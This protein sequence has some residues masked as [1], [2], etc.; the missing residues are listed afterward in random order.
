MEIFAKIATSL[1]GKI[2]LHN[3]ISKWI[4]C[5]ESRLI[6]HEL[7]AKAD[8]ILTSSTTAIK[9]NATLNVRLKNDI[10]VTQPKRILIDTDLKTPIDYNIFN[11]ENAGQTIVFCSKFA[12]ENKKQQLIKNNIEIYEVESKDGVLNLL[13]IRDILETLGLKSIMIEA[14]GRLLRAFINLGLVKR[15]IW[16]R[17]PI[18]IGN[19]GIPA[20]GNWGF[21]K[22]EQSLK[23]KLENIEKIGDDIMETYFILDKSC[24]QE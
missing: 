14:G 24:S 23:F 19:D 2:A 11:Q 3:G 10:L 4:S 17:A 18:I 9:D 6:V 12:N 20:F 22:I 16:F 21:E 5:E 7:R 15:L 1:D 13:Q 8:A